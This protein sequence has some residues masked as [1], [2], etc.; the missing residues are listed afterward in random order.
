M[1]YNTDRERERERVYVIQEL[2][3]SACKR[4]HVTVIGVVRTRHDH[5]R[6]DIPHTRQGD[7]VPGY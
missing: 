5:W 3:P 4:G 6:A 2:S 1:K 7:G